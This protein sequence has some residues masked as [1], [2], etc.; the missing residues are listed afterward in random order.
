MKSYGP[1]RIKKHNQKFIKKVFNDNQK[2]LTKTQLAKSTGLSVVTINKLLPEMIAKGEL[3]ELDNPIVTGGRK[4]SVYKL[5]A[6]YQTTL[7]VQYV[8]QN[9]E[10]T[11]NFSVVNLENQIVKKYRKYEE[12]IELN[13]LKKE[14]GCLL[15]EYPTISSLVIGV[16]GTEI[17]G[18]LKIM[19]YS[20]LLNINLTQQIRD[21]FHLPVIVENDINAATL[22]YS[23]K[24]KGNEKV[25]AGVYF[26][27]KFPPGASLV[28]HNQ[29]FHGGHGMS[30]EIKHVP[31]FC[32]Q[33][34]PITDETL[35]RERVME[36]LQILVS[37]YD[38]DEVVVYSESKFLPLD[39][40][41]EVL[42]KLDTLFP[43]DISFFIKKS[44]SFLEEYFIGLSFIG[45]QLLEDLED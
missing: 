32:R 28:I 14:I 12:Q 13:G 38:P 31:Q 18:Y 39:W 15:Q 8:A 26:P 23:L 19:D 33:E 16:P 11:A 25:I 34:F 20:A 3:I 29:L 24:N 7:I 9:E 4:A 21:T 40:E 5:N 45:I 22:G 37:L 36:S 2:P 30:G 41:K 1:E 42:S 35:Y 27:E 43:Y 6:N 10:M 44:S 17:N